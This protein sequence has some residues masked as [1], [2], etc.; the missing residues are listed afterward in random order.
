MGQH[1]YQSIAIFHFSLVKRIRL[2]H[3]N[4]SELECLGRCGVAYANIGLN[5]E[6]KTERRQ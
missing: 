3:L 5:N 4:Y 6:K 1:M 2:S